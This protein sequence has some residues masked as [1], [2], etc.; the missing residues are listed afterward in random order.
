MLWRSKACK[1]YFSLLLYLLDVLA[2]IRPLCGSWICG[3]GESPWQDG[4][5][6]SAIRWSSS[7]QSGWPEACCTGSRSNSIFLSERLDLSGLC[8]IFADTAHEARTLLSHPCTGAP[9]PSLSTA[10]QASK[11]V[12]AYWQ[13]FAN[14]EFDVLITTDVLSRGIDFAD[15]K[16]VMQLHPPKEARSVHSSIRKNWEGRAGRNMHHIL[17][18]IWAE[19]LATSAR[20]H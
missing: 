12:I 1:K 2:L 6:C 7:M 20:S 14:L 3:F 13:H 19:T 18:C 10:S 15:V 5:C 9:C 8:I 17:W 4:W 16:L 11:N